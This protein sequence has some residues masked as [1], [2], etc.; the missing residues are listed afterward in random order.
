M[1]EFAAF[2]AESLPNLNL[3]HLQIR[4]AVRA[5]VQADIAPFVAQWDE[6]GAIPRELHFKAASIGLLGLGYAAEYGGTPA[7]WRS[8]YLSTIEIARSGSGGISP[9]LMSHTIMVWPLLAKAS[10][11]IKSKVLPALFSGNAIG[12]LAITEADGGSDVAHLRT[13][14]NATANGWQLSGSK[15]YITSGTR[16]DYILTAAR[17]GGPGAAG[18]SLFLVPGNTPGL[19]KSLLNKTGWWCSDTAALYFD[20]CQLPASAL[21]GE[22]DKGFSLVMQNFNAERFLMAVSCVGYA[23]VMCEEALAWAQQ[24]KTFGHT[25]VNHQVV[26][27]KIMGMIESILAARAWS[28][29]IASQLDNSPTPEKALQQHAAQIALLKNHCGRLMRDCADTSIQILGGAGY[30]RATASERLYR[31]VK[32]MMIGGGAEEIMSDLAA[33][34]LGIF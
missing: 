5:F 11:P 13:Q 31:E 1:N 2:A 15:M 21:I 4:D 17:T 32:I 16:A 22:V 18:I 20:N 12:A 33:K 14:A 23:M 29:E 24:R 27:Q 3:E 34:Q 8:R 7:D 6:A 30:M 9:A 25:L 10:E 26:R 19:S 28:F